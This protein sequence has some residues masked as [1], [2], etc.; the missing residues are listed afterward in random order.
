MSHHLESETS[1][2]RPTSRKTNSVNLIRLVAA[3]AIFV[4]G[5]AT[6]FW[7][8][9]GTLAGETFSIDDTRYTTR[10]YIS[11]DR[12]FAQCST[13]A[14]GGTTLQVAPLQSDKNRNGHIALDE[15]SGQIM[16][17]LNGACVARYDTASNHM[18]PETVAKSAAELWS[19]QQSHGSS[20]ATTD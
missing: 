20:T 18:H 6:Y 7:T 2:K 11:G 15:P 9:P 17:S 3:I 12:V 8:S 10:L 5:L 14:G 4:I 13:S 19:A 16:F 1:T